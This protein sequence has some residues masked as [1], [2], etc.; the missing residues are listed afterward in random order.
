M[1]TC[2]IALS[3]CNREDAP[4]CF[5]KAGDIKT[6]QRD[7]DDFFSIELNDYIQYELL[8]TTYFGVI[9]TAPG[10]LIDDIET[11]VKEGELVIRN[12]NRCN[13]VR[14][15]KNKISIRI[16]APDFR[17]IQ[18]YATGDIISVNAITGDLFSIENR[19]AAGLQQLT[20]MTDTV[21]IAS[22]TGVSDAV[23]AGECDVL[24]LFSQG[25]GKVDALELHSNHAFV[26]NSSL[27]DVFV[28]AKNYLFS[29]IEFSGNIFYSGNPAVIDESIEGEGQL[30][31]L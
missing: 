23:I 1:V 11:E 18:N 21:N 27:N 14:S 24:Y 20:L 22:H 12:A 16:C 10:N 15:Y 17:D 5:Q 28:F 8:D 7:L 13:F 29:Y 4:D 6:I 9:I 31:P 30:I 19:G 2:A 25:L 3:S 26:N